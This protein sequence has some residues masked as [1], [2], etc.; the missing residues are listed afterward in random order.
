M[1]KLDGNHQTPYIKKK[2]TQLVT[3]AKVCP[4]VPTSL[5]RLTFEVHESVYSLKR[6]LIIYT[7]TRCY[8]DNE[9]KK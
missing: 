3:L 7:F 8:S 5:L 9:I 1:H 2:I 4:L 6:S